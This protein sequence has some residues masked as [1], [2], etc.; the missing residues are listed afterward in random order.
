MST[1]VVLV[2][3]ESLVDVLTDADGTRTELPG[4]SPAN[5]AVA[6]ARL[7]TRVRLLTA[8]A[9]DRLGSIVAEY[10][11]EP[12]VELAADPQVL[13]RTSSAV[14]TLDATGSASYVFDISGVLPVPDL[15]LPPT[16]V[17]VGSLGAVLPPG[18]DLLAALV[19]RLAA[20]ATISYDINARPSAV[21]LDAATRTRIG[22]MVAA[23]DVVKASDEDLAAWLPDLS[24]GDAA[25]RLVGAGAGVV[26]VTLGSEGARCYTGRGLVAEVPGE[27]VV[28]RDTIGAGDVFCAT[29]LDTLRGRGLLGADRR[30]ALYDVAADD[31]T[32]ILRRATRAAGITVSRTGASGPTPAELD[33]A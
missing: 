17:H 16:H 10:V 13:D 22:A 28:V 4:G 33:G 1:P 15:S 18:A 6:L 5:V 32:E 25:A 8:Y 30:A 7:G 9:A 23:S 19:A 31:W 12:G 21:P 27:D 11:G 20:T 3:G 26:V 29:L 14:A 2:A 24:V